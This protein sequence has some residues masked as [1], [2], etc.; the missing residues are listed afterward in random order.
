MREQEHSVFDLLFDLLCCAITSV[1]VGLLD[2]TRVFGPD[3]LLSMLLMLLK[4]EPAS[5][6]PA[7]AAAGSQAVSELI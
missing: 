1:L 2:E 5:A 7:P 4:R 3:E 6:A